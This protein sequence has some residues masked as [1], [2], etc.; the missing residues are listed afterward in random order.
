VLA[1]ASEY[2][3]KRLDSWDDDRWSL[4]AADGKPLLVAGVE[5]ELH[6]AAQAVV[7]LM[8]EEVVPEGTAALQLAQVCCCPGRC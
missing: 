8:Y 3:C 4:T 5:E 6:A 1:G 2:F 7:R